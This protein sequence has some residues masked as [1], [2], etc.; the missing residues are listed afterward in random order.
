MDPQLDLML[1]Q[2]IQSFQSGDLDRA[3]TILNRLL[4]VQPKNLP[5]LHILGLIKASLSKHTEAAELLKR[6]V[7][8]N[9]QDPS[10]QYNLAKALFESGASMDSLPHHKK[11]IELS[12]GNP[13]A[14]L[15]YGKSLS[16]LS[17]HDEALAI[18]EKSLSIK[19]DFAEALIN[20][21]ATLKE[22]KR[23]EEAL[24]SADLALKLNP[25]LVEAWSNKATALKEL[26]L[27]KEALS[28]YEKVIDFNL[29]YQDAWCN[30][31]IIYSELKDYDAALDCYAK[32][33]QLKPDY[34]E[35]WYN[36][37]IAYS[38]LGRYEDAITS[39]NNAIN[40]GFDFDYLPGILAQTQLLAGDWDA[41]GNSVE[42][43]VENIKLGE[44][45]V[46]PFSLLPLTDS[47]ALHLQAAKT[48]VNDKYPGQSSLGPINKNL[49]DKIR[50]GYF[51]ADFKY[52][53]VSLL[54]VELFE[55]HDRNQF[56]VFAFSLQSA[57]EDD[58]LRNRLIKAFDH[59]IEVGNKNEQEIAS[60]ARSYEIDIAIDLGG[61]TLN[62]KPGIFLCRAAPIQVNYLGYPG[63]IGGDW[64]DYII[65]DPIVIPEESRH[66]YTEAVALLPNSY[67]VDD[68]KRQP[69]SNSLSR[70]AFNLPNDKFIFCCF[71]NSY[72]FNKENVYVWA[73]ILREVDN[74]VLW[75][76]ENN[77]YFRANLLK[78]FLNLGIPL[79]RIIF[80]AKLES[81]EDHLARYRLAD[82]FLDTH[83]YNAH[84]TALD[85]LKA[86]LPLLTLQGK[87]FASRVSASLLAA[88]ELPEL[89]TRT[90]EE[91]ISVAI[92]LANNPEILNKLKA[93]LAKNLLTSPLFD[94]K[95]FTADIEDIYLEMYK[96][97]QTNLK[98]DYISLKPKILS[99]SSLP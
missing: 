81:M 4:L 35:A 86:G 6:A 68:S 87:S 22:L 54:T 53:P 69:S 16:Q 90:K 33:I 83:P 11:A 75:V 98:P 65:A 73:K 31:G 28:C 9:P 77:G 79:S 21:G 71:N 92:N 32:A 58:L 7:R 15:N 84:T 67:M 38:D 60:L 18:Y 23:Y 57:H 45:V 72:K 48:W 44:R 40:L 20:K 51:S 8:I 1:N 55:L 96:R 49:H 50:I 61:H 30:K 59:F 46:F 3:Q 47:P 27:Y 85:S 76:S 26:K 42:V 91:Y 52:H 29:D 56:E 36:Q 25:T 12:P 99:R 39:F 10:L 89:V 17:R 5:A 19:P 13:E 64:M 24:N 94:T 14:W 37:G 41:L 78:E 93:R 70:A 82:L 95:S 80:A 62:A 97:Y 88:V 34:Q 63:T 43:L 74:G 66:H 2:A